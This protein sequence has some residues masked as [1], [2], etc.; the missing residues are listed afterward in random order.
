[1][2][3]KLTQRLTSFFQSVC[4]TET[5]REDACKDM[6]TI[7]PL[8]SLGGRAN[9]YSC[10]TV[11]QIGFKAGQVMRPSAALASGSGQAGR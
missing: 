2:L 3:K 9:N 7:R 10:L 6:Q 5:K 11:W 4:K 8:H 1:M